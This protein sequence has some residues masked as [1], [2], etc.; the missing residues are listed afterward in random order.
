VATSVGRILLDEY[1]KTWA[2]RYLREAKVDLAAAETTPTASKSVHLSLLAM[3]KM[4]AAIYY[5][6]GDPS[7]LVFLVADALSEAANGPDVPTDFLAQVE[8]LIQ[9]RSAK[10]SVSEKEDALTEAKQL[11]KLTVT[12]VNAIL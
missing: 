3:R 2:L 4:Q 8:W 10:A 9:I 1:R 12:I 11:M 7:Y 6:L 5:C